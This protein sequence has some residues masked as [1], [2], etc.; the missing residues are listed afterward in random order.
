MATKKRNREADRARVKAWRKAN[1]EK[2]RA[3]G[4][5]YYS[6]NKAKVQAR[7]RDRTVRDPFWRRANVLRRYGL[8]RDDYDRILCDQGYSCAV[9]GRLF[10]GLT[11]R[12]ICLDHD[13][14]TGRFRAVLCHWCN[15]MLGGAQDRPDVLNAGAEY[16]E[17]HRS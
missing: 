12:Q 1:P 17:K 11:S 8:T 13:H 2:R 9:C 7:H 5:R 4:R 14:V 3:Q 16:L 15:I 6:K 10:A